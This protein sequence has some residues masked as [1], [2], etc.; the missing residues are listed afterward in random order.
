MRNNSLLRY[1]KY[2]I[3]FVFFPI[4]TTLY[5]YRKMKNN[6]KVPKGW[7]VIKHFTVSEFDS[8]D[9]RGSG[10]SMHLDFVAVLDRIRERLNEPM[11]V[12]SGFRTEAH[13][14]KV[15]G[16]G[17]SAH[18]RGW[19]ADI[20]CPDTE[21]MKRLCSIASQ[22]GIKRMFQYHTKAGN[23]FVHMDMDSGKPDAS[24]CFLYDSKLDKMIYFKGE[25]IVPYNVA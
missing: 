9:V 25:H 17:D 24:G 10:L 11:H 15:G 8:P 22:E 14:K 3:I 13:N 1:V 23:Y 12:N 6:T 19:A 16:V 2:L 18:T 21:Y 5:L 4:V 20:A 7:E